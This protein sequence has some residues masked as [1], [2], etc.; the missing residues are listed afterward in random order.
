MEDMFRWMM[1]EIQKQFQQEP[2]Y[3]P[4]AVV[5]RFH[6]NGRSKTYKKNLRKTMKLNRK[7]R[8]K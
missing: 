6:H 8:M 1:Y 7:R 5:S 2:S 4:L 3:N